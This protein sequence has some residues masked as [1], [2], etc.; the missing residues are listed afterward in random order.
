M[1]TLNINNLEEGEGKEQYY[2]E[3]SSMSAALGDLDT[4]LEINNAW[5]T[6]RENIII[7]AED[8]LDYY[9]LKMKMKDSQN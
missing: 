3:V 2:V 8:S 5:E 9:Q 7:S 1:G 4:E 6:I